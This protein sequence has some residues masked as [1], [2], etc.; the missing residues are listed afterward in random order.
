[1]IL[2]IFIFMVDK[3]DT[4]NK[5]EF[6]VKN[7]IKFYAEIL[8]KLE[9]NTYLEIKI[10]LIN[11]TNFFAFPKKYINSIL[12]L[13]YSNNIY[14]YDNTDK[15]PNILLYLSPICVLCKL[16]TFDDTLTQNSLKKLLHIYNLI[17]YNFNIPFQMHHIL[18]YAFIL[19]ANEN[20][21]RLIYYLNNSKLKCTK[22]SLFN[23]MF[24]KNNE[25]N[26]S[27]YTEEKYKQINN[28]LNLKYDN[29]ENFTEKQ[30]NQLSD[31]IENELKLF[32]KYNINYKHLEQEIR[33]KG[34]YTPNELFKYYI[35]TIKF[36]TKQYITDQFIYNYMLNKNG[37][38][39]IINLKLVLYNYFSSQFRIEN[40]LFILE[41]NYTLFESN[42]RNPHRYFLQIGFILELYIQFLNKTKPKTFDPKLID[43]FK[44]IQ[45]IIELTN[46]YNKLIR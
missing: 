30:F 31:N 41:N 26:L 28:Y 17:P 40:Q 39:I 7:V 19:G 18:V 45:S 9:E 14:Q 10:L 42:I 20:E 32:E 16:Q 4:Q 29:N 33:L 11:N 38:D 23:E 15:T 44:I 46:I 6:S 1:M 3:L 37:N 13:F 35:I 36:I 24:T 27:N 5:N 12:K 43:Q 2:F 22:Q 21:L 34:S 25:M 8:S